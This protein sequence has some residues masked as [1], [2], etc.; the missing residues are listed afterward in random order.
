MELKGQTSDQFVAC[1]TGVILWSI[2]F[3][4]L[5]LESSLSL[6]TSPDRNSGG[7]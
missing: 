6:F 7:T 4:D 2:D 1:R 5:V 3:S